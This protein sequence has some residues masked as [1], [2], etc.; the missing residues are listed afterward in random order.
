[1]KAIAAALLKVQQ[2]LDPVHKGKKG[3]GYSY[4]DLPAVMDSCLEAL[5]KAG[6][7]MVQAPTT[8]DKQAAAIC[9]RLIHAESGEEIY[10]V[11]EVPLGTNAKMSDAQAYGSAMTY[12]RRY[13]LVSMLGIVT[14][15]D[16]GATAGKCLQAVQRA[17][18]HNQFTDGGRNDDI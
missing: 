6:V 17:E 11:I 1:M 2:G 12:G 9:T 5:N 15:D 10:G 4:A 18:P 14:E 7:V 16:D 8:T 3:Y 13:A